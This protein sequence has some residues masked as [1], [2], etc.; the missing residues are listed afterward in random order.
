M[1]LSSYYSSREIPE[2]AYW[3]SDSELRL[4]YFDHGSNNTSGIAPEGLN[5]SCALVG[6][7]QQ[8][9]AAKLVLD[10]LMSCNINLQNFQMGIAASLFRDKHITIA[11]CHAATTLQ[12]NPK[13]SR[14]TLSLQKSPS[15]HLAH[16]QIPRRY[17]ASLRI[18]PPEAG[19]QDRQND[20]IPVNIHVYGLQL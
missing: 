18:R 7:R 12:P 2:I 1:K 8:L 13:F 11:I 16:C 15:A 20:V 17:L 3:N 5:V 10:L 4:L 14:Q 6:L 19:P 9:M